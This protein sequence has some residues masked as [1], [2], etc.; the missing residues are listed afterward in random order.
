MRL[1]D[2]CRSSD[3]LAL[4]A[5]AVETSAG[6]LLFLGHA[7]AGKSTICQLLAK[8]FPILA[9]D[10]V[11]LIR[12]N[13]EGGAWFVADGSQHAFAE[14]SA[15]AVDS[16]PSMP[17][18]AIFRIYQDSYTRLVRMTPRETCSHLVDAL[19]EISWQ[20]HGNL[21]EK[22]NWFNCVAEVAR[23]YRGARL[24]FSLDMETSDLELL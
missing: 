15:N 6:V 10:A 23:R 24:Y 5:S 1:S 22:R 17:L 3:V 21:V 19:F 4:H 18:R 12:K 11:Y 2:A 16:I 14:P 20:Q 7:G 8:R 13:Q 9:D